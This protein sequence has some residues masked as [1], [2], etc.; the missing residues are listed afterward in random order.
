MGM[1]LEKTFKDFRVVPKLSLEE[2]IIGLSD[3][4]S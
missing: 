4:K 2:E 3:R 1:R